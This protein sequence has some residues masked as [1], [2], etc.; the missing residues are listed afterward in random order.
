MRS[1]SRLPIGR[2]CKHVEKAILFW[3]KH[4]L[5]LSV[6]DNDN[7]INQITKLQI[8]TIPKSQANDLKGPWT[9]RWLDIF[10][11]HLFV[12][13]QPTRIA[14]PCRGPGNQVWSVPTSTFLCR[15]SS[16][17]PFTRRL[18]QF[19]C[20]LQRNMQ[21]GHIKH[22]CLTNIALEPCNITTITVSSAHNK[23][24]RNM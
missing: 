11:I 21:F 7:N 20:C 8:Y 4:A 16:A 23:F 1:S 19:M 15:L 13:K 6:Q 2:I 22:I 17:P 12:V 18:N 3:E 9:W 5:V 24:F 14:M 10:R